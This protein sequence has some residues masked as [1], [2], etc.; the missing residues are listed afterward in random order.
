[1]SRLAA[2]CVAR[3]IA[4]G[5]GNSP[6]GRMVFGIT[7]RPLP[8][9]LWQESAGTN[10]REGSPPSP[11]PSP[12]GE[13]MA[14]ARLVCTDSVVADPAAGRFR[15]S[16]RELLVRRIL[17]PAQWLPKPASRWFPEN[18]LSLRDQRSPSEG[19]RES[20]S[21]DR[22]LT[23][24]RARLPDQISERKPGSGK[25]TRKGMRSAFRGCPA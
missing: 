23:N 12:P 18:S 10:W 19:A 8:M 7:R 3:N 11:L 24:E 17:T 25:T 9:N 14:A 22:R 16:K 4:H 13:G 20:G 6:M 21:D 1:M 15:G 5:C 2:D